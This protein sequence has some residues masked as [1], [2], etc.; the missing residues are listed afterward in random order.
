[1]RM[2][3]ARALVILAGV[4]LAGCETTSNN[5]SDL[6]KPAD[7]T[8]QASASALADPATAGSADPATAAMAADIPVDANRSAT[9]RVE[10]AALE[11]TSTVPA[12]LGVPVEAEPGLL[13]SDPNDDLSLGKKQYRANNFGLAEKYFRRAVETHPRDAE[14]WLGLAASYDRLRR[15]D[16]ADRAYAQAVKIVGPTIEVLN[17]Q[18]Y[19]YMLRGDYRRAR[20]RLI[21]AQRKDPGNKYVA[22]NLHLLAESYRKGKAIE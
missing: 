15:F 5:L 9:T 4:S 8:G 16:L 18:G 14:A 17:N 20:E 1:M 19:S 3:V 22:N 12:P 7:S 13:G 2:S 6:F 10:T 21:A 11:T